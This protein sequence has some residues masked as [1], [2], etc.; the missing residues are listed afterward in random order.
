MNIGIPKERRPFEFRVGLPPEG[1]DTLVSQGNSVYVEAG[2]GA[3][4]GFA[5][6]DYEKAGARI[7]YSPEEAFGRANLLLKFARPLKEEN[8][9]HGKKRP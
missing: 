5:D 6:V 3:G 2:A 4:A 7:V 9:R 8:S 1:V